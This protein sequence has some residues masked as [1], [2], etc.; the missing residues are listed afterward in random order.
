MSRRLEKR[1]EL[2]DE[3]TTRGDQVIR[4]S[5]ASR[6]TEAS[7]E[8]L[9][10]PPRRMESIAVSNYLTRGVGM[11]LVPASARP[12]LFTAFSPPAVLLLFL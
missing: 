7:A 10:G 12:H 11:D 5:P 6:G 4:E 8:V 3:L 2:R 1:E 9:V